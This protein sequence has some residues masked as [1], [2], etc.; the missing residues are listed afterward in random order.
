MASAGDIDDDG[1]DDLIKDLRK[2]GLGC[3]VG[4]IWM[5]AVGFAAF[6][7]AL[8]LSSLKRAPPKLVA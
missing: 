3:R 7:A 8:E 4:G 1:L 5:A 6:A 2:L